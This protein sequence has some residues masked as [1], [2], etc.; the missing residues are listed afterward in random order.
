MQKPTHA[1]IRFHFNI[2]KFNLN[3][4]QEYHIASN[5]DKPYLAAV[6]LPTISAKQFWIAAIILHL[7][8]FLQAWHTSSIYLVDSIDYISQ[9]ENIKL[10]GS[11]YAA[12][13]QGPIKPDYYSFR[14]PVYG[15]IIYCL[16]ALVQTDYAILFLQLLI[17]LSTIWGVLKLAKE[18]GLN[19]NTTRLT[20]LINQK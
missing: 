9:A 3:K 18:L 20:E 12:P 15:F 16:K 19:Q 2:P 4:S 13:W 6:N 7:L 1:I 8:G 14:P 17:S 11:L 5:M 10:H